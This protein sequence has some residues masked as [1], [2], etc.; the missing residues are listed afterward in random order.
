MEW[1]HRSQLR[2][3]CREETWLSKIQ[4]RGN[5][6]GKTKERINEGVKESTAFCQNTSLITMVQ[7]P[8]L[9]TVVRY[10][11]SSLC[12]APGKFLVQEKQDFEFAQREN[13]S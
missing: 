4:V 8:K 5:K 6:N 10:I 2:G 13:C 11:E 7:K 3:Y 1:K 9:L 12:F